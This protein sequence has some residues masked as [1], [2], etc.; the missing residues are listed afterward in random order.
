MARRPARHVT[1]DI[2][3]GL[4]NREA[5]LLS[6]DPTSIASAWDPVDVFSQDPVSD[7]ALPR[8]SNAFPAVRSMLTEI[9][10][11]RFTEASPRSS[12]SRA[13]I[14]LSARAGSQSAL[15]Q[16]GFRSPSFVMVCVRRRRRRQVIFAKGRG[17]GGKRRG[18]RNYYS[19]I[20]C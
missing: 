13:R 7:Y 5:S 15:Y 11:R 16:L 18:R 4:P 12:R 2:L 17:G 6:R 9:E 14:Q 10:D 20:W 8:L 1:A 19:N 3:D